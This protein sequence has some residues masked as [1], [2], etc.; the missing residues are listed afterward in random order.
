MAISTQGEAPVQGETLG[1]R[2]LAELRAKTDRDLARIVARAAE[3]GLWR[4][5]ESAFDE[6]EA[7]YQQITQLLPLLEQSPEPEVRLV[8]RQAAELRSELDHATV[9]G[10][11]VLT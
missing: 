5:H 11:G 1:T 4:A 2:K 3:L 10:A 6:A 7:I 8:R 9:A